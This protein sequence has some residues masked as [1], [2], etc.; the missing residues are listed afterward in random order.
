MKLPDVL[1]TLKGCSDYWFRPVSW[2]G[3]GRAYCLIGGCTALVPSES[4]GQHG[5]TCWP[6][7]LIEDWEI[8]SARTVLDE[9][10]TD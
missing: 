9:R 8:V 5:M 2:Q 10:A 7:E 6:K 4:G 1:E 3:Q